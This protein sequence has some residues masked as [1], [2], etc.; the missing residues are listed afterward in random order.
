LIN[1]ANAKNSPVFICTLDAEKCFDAI[2]HDGLFM[3]LADFLSPQNWLLLRRW[4]R[5]LRAVVRWRGK[6]SP[7]FRVTKGTRQGSVLS[8]SLFNAFIDGLLCELAGSRDG[9]SIGPDHYTHV[10][11][12]DDITLVSATATGLQRLI[13]RCCAYA[14]VWRFRYNPRKSVCMIAGRTSFSSPPQWTLYDA[15]IPTEPQLEVLGV[16]FTPAN[17][18]SRHL[19]LRQL[20]CRRS[21][22]S[23]G[24]AGIMSRGLHPHVKSH[25]WSTVCQPVALYGCETVALRPRDIRS[26]ESLQGCL[27][28][29]ALGVGKRSH[30][31][32]LLRAMRIDSMESLIDRRSVKLQRAILDSDSPARRL[33]LYMASLPLASLPM[34]A[35]TLSS[36]LKRI[37]SCLL[38]P[39]S[40]PETAPR[41]DGI[42]DSITNILCHE[43]FLK[44]Y[45]DEL[46]LLRLLTR[47]F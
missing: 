4:Y 27:V 1:I 26:L 9:I 23:L 36:R 33:A 8:P 19:E 45:S 39:V 14:N 10:A 32:A 6:T 2:W 42:T 5:A 25:L 44:P 29:K 12:A 22:F 34:P 15:N 16:T 41:E 21:F 7:E 46:I 40:P 38:N 3:K 31:S 37:G 17:D 35:N 18:C 11:Y 30:H 43:N 20:K 24:S 13:D 47:S 28:K